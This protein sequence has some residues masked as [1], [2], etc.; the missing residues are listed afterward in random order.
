[1]SISYN[2][3]EK[4]HIRSRLSPI[5]FNSKHTLS[6]IPMQSDSSMDKMI[7]DQRK[8]R[9]Y[10]DSLVKEKN[11][12]IGRMDIRKLHE[13]LIIIKD[14][15]EL[16][17]EKLVKRNKAAITIQSIVRGWLVRKLYEN[18]FI[19]ISREIAVSNLQELD[20][21]MPKLSIFGKVCLKSVLIIQRCYRR[22]K[23]LKKISRLKKVY[24]LTIKNNAKVQAK[25]ILRK[26][27]KVV[28]SRLYIF[29]IKENIQI[30][31]ELRRIRENLSIITIKNYFNDNHLT[32]ND[33]CQRYKFLRIIPIENDILEIKQKNCKNFRVHHTSVY[34]PRRSVK[35]YTPI[36]L[37]KQYKLSFPTETI[38]SKSRIREPSQSFLHF[39][40]RSDYSLCSKYT[41]PSTPYK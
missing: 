4:I 22:Y 24:N 9:Y 32:I 31:K 40:A 37:Q 3:H 1:M 25:R 29:R 14:K 10:I 26:Y 12:I 23:M 33:I 13:N 27:F 2:I 36:L 15:K 6:M 34:F 30:R 39:R 8:K 5:T 35:R 11:R 17:A 18:E 38:I 41:R 20:K 7:K 28:T 16:K 19:L 21:C